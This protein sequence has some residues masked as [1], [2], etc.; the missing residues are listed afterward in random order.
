MSFMQQFELIPSSRKRSA[1]ER[2]KLLEKPVFGKVF[3]DHMAM[4]VVK[5]LGTVERFS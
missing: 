4:S 1:A 2:M 3:T 5:N